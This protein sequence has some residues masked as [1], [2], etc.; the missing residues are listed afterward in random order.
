MVVLWALPLSH[1]AAL[2]ACGGET[3]VTCEAWLI[4]WRR[5]MPAGGVATGF[6]VPRG[7]ALGE[8]DGA[9]KCR[10]S[11]ACVGVAGSMLGFEARLL[12]C[13]RGSVW[14]ARLQARRERLDC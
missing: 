12:P 4:S 3:G 2:D 10:R 9:M 1:R 13:E 8:V 6:T 7:D 11:P 5:K 14:Q